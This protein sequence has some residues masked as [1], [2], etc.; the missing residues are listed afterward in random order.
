MPPLV[1]GHGSVERDPRRCRSSGG[2]VIHRFLCLRFLFARDR[3]RIPRG[4][5]GR[6]GKVR[7]RHKGG[8]DSWV[9]ANVLGRWVLGARVLHFLRPR[10]DQSGA[11]SAQGLSPGSKRAIARRKAPPS[12]GSRLE[13][14]RAKTQT[15]ASCNSRTLAS[16]PRFPDLLIPADVSRGIAQQP[17]R[18]YGRD[19]FRRV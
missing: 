18:F 19:G 8:L 17:R 1:G 5:A 14:Q 10:H 16:L 6:G 7:H 4:S 12:F 2:P 11:D 15:P 9:A 13:S 3:Q